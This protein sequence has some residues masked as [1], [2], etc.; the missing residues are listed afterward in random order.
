MLALA[1]GVRQGE[2]EVTAQ[3]AV[4]EE[5]QLLNRFVVDDSAEIASFGLQQGCLALDFHDFR[6]CAE[7]QTDI[8]AR[9]GVHLHQDFGDLGLAKAFLFGAHG[10][11]AGS[12]VEEVI[13]AFGS[14]IPWFA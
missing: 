9:S 4:D 1:P 8:D 10:V 7:L 12:E 2:R 13:G 6:Q 3:S 14:R 11:L 5:R